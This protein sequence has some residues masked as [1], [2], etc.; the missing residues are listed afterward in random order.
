MKKALIITVTLLAGFVLAQQPNLATSWRLIADDS[1][2]WD[3]AST[4]YI[5][6]ARVNINSPAVPSIAV[7]ASA[8]TSNAV[9]NNLRIE[10]DANGAINEKKNAYGAGLK[11]QALWSTAWTNRVAATYK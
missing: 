9:W 8:S 1:N 7:P 10:V 5:G 11:D 6:K 2:V 3:A 4:N